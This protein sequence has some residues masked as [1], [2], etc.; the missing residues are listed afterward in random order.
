MGGVRGSTG[1]G[2]ERTQHRK[3]RDIWAARGADENWEQGSGPLRAAG[4]MGS[5][6]HV[7]CAPPSPPHI[8]CRPQAVLRYERAF[9]QAVASMGAHRAG[10]AAAGGSSDYRMSKYY[11]WQQTHNS[12][13]IAIYLPTGVAPR[14][15]PARAAACFAQLAICVCHHQCN[16]PQA[17]L[18]HA[19]ARTPLQALPAH[20]WRW[21]PAPLACAWRPPPPRL[22]WSGSGV[23]PLTPPAAATAG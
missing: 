17:R 22:W 1:V 3:L 23:A 19:P 9:R 11:M 5:Y 16:P 14:L 2:D 6:M 18:A 15:Y 10:A 12:I 8:G 7:G 20:G 4:G 21:M 13:H